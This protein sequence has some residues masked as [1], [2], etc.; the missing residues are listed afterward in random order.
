MTA[1]ISLTAL[2]ALLAIAFPLYNN[3]RV[4]R[5]RQQLFA[6]RDQLFDDALNGRIRF[7]SPA[8]RVTRTMLNGMIRFGHR[9]SWSGI[10]TTLLWR[11]AHGASSA[12]DMIAKILATASPAD[13]AVCDAYMREA[14]RATV[15]HIVSSPMT[16]VLVVPALVAWTGA[17]TTAR[18]LQRLQNS[19]KALDAS[20][21]DEGAAAQPG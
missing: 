11:R 18:G 14:H 7:D 9:I 4:D 13:R 2:A 15:R 3:Y 10:L 6:L 16:Y 17:W 20:A 5:L 12:E 19:F 8:Y 1:L 21:Y